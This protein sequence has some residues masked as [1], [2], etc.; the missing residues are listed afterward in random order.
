MSDVWPAATRNARLELLQCDRIGCEHFCRLLGTSMR[1]TRSKITG[2]AGRSSDSQSHFIIAAY[3]LQIH[4]A[5]VGT[6]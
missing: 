1:R 2:E 4:F 3:R 5:R 6:S